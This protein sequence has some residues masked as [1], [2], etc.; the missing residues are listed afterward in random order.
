VEEGKDQNALRI[1]EDDAKSRLRDGG[2]CIFLYLT[3]MIA[4]ELVKWK[5]SCVIP[6][7]AMERLR[8]KTDGMKGGKMEKIRSTRE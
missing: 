8:E 2:I 6:S 7:D 1:V 3:I 4:V 5:K